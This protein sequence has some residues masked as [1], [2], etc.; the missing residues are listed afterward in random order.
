MFKQDH[1]RLAKLVTATFALN[2]LGYTALPIAMVGATSGMAPANTTDADKAEKDKQQKEAAVATAEAQKKAVD[3]A[4]KSVVSID[5]DEKDDLQFLNK[6]ILLC[7]DPS[8]KTRVS[9]TYTKLIDSAKASQEKAEADG[10]EPDAMTKK[11]IAVDKRVHDISDKMAKSGTLNLDSVPANVMNSAKKDYQKGIA[12]K[13]LCEAEAER[14]GKDKSAC[15]LSD[16]AKAASN[17]LLTKGLQQV[18]VT[19]TSGATTNATEKKGASKEE[20]VDTEWK[21]GDDGLWHSV[22]KV[23]ESPKCADDEVVEDGKCVKKPA[24][25]TKTKCADDEILQDGKCVKKETTTVKCADDEVIENGKCVKK[26][27]TTKTD[28][29]CTSDE[30]LRDGKCVKKGTCVQTLDKH[31]LPAND[32]TGVSP[33]KNSSKEKDDDDW[34]CAE[35]EEPGNK[36]GECIKLPK[37]KDDEIVTGN[38]STGFKCTQKATACKADEKLVDGVCKE[39]EPTEC[40][41]QPGDTITGK[42]GYSWCCPKGQTPGDKK[43]SCIPKSCAEGEELKDGKCVKKTDESKCPATGYVESNGQCCPTDY[44]VYDASKQQCVKKQDDS[45]PKPGGNSTNKVVEALGTIGAL[46]GIFGGKHHKPNNPNTID[47][48]QLQF[49]FNYL[50]GKKTNG[51]SKNDIY[52]FPTDSALPIKFKLFQYRLPAAQPGQNA[53]P[54]AVAHV[55]MTMYNDQTKQWA[56]RTITLPLELNQM[57]MLFPS[58]LN[59]GGAIYLPLKQFGTIERQ[60][61]SKF[62]L[63]YYTM[64]VVADDGISGHVREFNIKYDFTADTTLITSNPD[65]DLKKGTDVVQGHAPTIGLDGYVQGATW[66]AASQTCKIAVSGT[67]TDTAAN[68]RYDTEG[69]SSV[70]IT[71]DKYNESGCNKIAGASGHSIHMEGLGE[72][73]DGKGHR[74]LSDKDAKNAKIAIYSSDDIATY[75]N[76]GQQVYHEGIFKNSDFKEQYQDQL[77]Y[78]RRPTD[79]TVTY[80]DGHKESWPG[81]S[82]D[83]STLYDTDGNELTD[84]QKAKEVQLVCEKTGNADVCQNGA[85]FDACSANKEPDR[86]GQVCLVR[87]DGTEEVWS[88]GTGFNR[89]TIGVQFGISTQD[90]ATENAHNT[91]P[92]YG[93]DGKINPGA[94][95]RG[96]VSTVKDIA[97]NIYDTVT[98]SDHKD[99]TTTVPKVA[100]NEKA[101][102]ADKET[103]L[104]AQMRNQEAQVNNTREDG[105]TPKANSDGTSTIVNN[106]K[107]QKVV[108]TARDM[109]NSA[110]TIGAGVVPHTAK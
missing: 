93:D 109:A 71:S 35:G 9:D 74:I 75:K 16:D 2:T 26:P 48:N 5:P 106:S 12:D 63:P 79:F 28:P 87:K 83:G 57:T 64:T 45:K 54:S 36:P 101:D 108:N 60:P 6:V 104:N 89:N 96:V 72:S 92:L 80:A 11:L 10:V 32:S 65:K 102:Q 38:A 25:T 77:Q 91:T 23:K 37:C 44:P 90:A 53:Q 99:T 95:L 47:E 56:G 4:Y 78:A 3:Q 24:T 41:M 73:D 31:Y 100:A 21:K 20:N 17:F 46:A 85:K 43:D 76:D 69:D 110:K 15:K 29:K 103:A 14:D 1:K 19:S 62:G 86:L 34:C 68:E 49:T 59:E 42:K 55:M 66:D 67:F 88:S 30:L 70:E 58:T 84:S 97:K 8:G 40:V 105:A 52:L 98:G 51:N 107:V 82:S 81:Y 18:N 39:K 61:A 27:T 50:Q 33:S 13:K 94:V 22:H 7:Q